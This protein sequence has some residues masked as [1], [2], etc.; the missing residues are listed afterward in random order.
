MQKDLRGKGQEIKSR[1]EQEREKSYNSPPISVK[2]SS[3]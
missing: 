2:A 3:G 1:V